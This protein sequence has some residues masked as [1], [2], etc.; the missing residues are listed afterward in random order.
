MKAYSKDLR[1]RVLDA[2]DRGVPR[3]EVAEQFQV[4]LRT[5]KRWLH[6]RRELGHLAVSPRPGAPARKMG[7]LR[8]GLL[9][10]LEARPDA[11]APEARVVPPPLHY[12]TTRP[13]DADFYPSAP[14][15]EH[16][17]A[18]V[19]PFVGEY[20]T[21]EGSG[22]YGLSAWTAPNTPVPP[23]RSVF[24]EVA[25]YLAFGFSVTWDGPPAPATSPAR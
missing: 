17:P 4:S 24:R 5:I 19:T 12:E 6:R 18:F 21:A 25:G 1:I 15:V 9:P 7:P 2:V 3:P 11:R 8:T 20:A 13:P 23:V 10:H 16:D 22:R 14:L